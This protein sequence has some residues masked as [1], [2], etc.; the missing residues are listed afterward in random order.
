[1]M[2]ISCIDLWTFIPVIGHWIASFSDGDA[3][4]SEPTKSKHFIWNCMIDSPTAEFSL[5]TSTL[6]NNGAHMILIH[7]DVVSSLG[8]PIFALRTPELVDVAISAS[9]EK[10]NTSLLHFVK[11]KLTSIDDQWTSL[12]SPLLLHQAFVCLL[13]WA[14]PS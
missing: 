3:S 4:I 12:P 5:K 11:F 9:N 7:P 1:M 6:I 13:F 10:K 14:F 8:F 2:T